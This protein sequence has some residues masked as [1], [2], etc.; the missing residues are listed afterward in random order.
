[1]LLSMMNGVDEQ[2]KRDCKRFISNHFDA[3][4]DDIEL[5]IDHEYEHM[6]NYLAS[7]GNNRNNTTC[8]A[9]HR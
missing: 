8:K 4:P 7:Q 3:Y 1:M 2:A 5:M 6:I 9:K